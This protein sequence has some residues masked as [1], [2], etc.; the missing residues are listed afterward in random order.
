MA[1]RIAQ[2]LLLAFV[3]VSLAWLGVKQ[4]RRPAAASVAVDLSDRIEVI[5][6][7]GRERCDTCNKIEAWSHEALQD[8]FAAQLADQRV[9]WRV[10]NFETPEN[11]PLKKKYKLIAAAVVVSHVRGGEELSWQKVGEVWDK[12]LDGDKPGL[13][14]VVQAAVRGQLETK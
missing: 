6:F 4:F 8:G 13:F 11:E 12:V 2:V 10:E 9:R 14:A 5:Y 1:R 7:H 3:G